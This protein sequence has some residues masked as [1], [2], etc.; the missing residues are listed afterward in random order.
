MSERWFIYV[1]EG[2]GG[3][4]RLQTG[5]EKGTWGAKSPGMFEGL[6]DGET[7]TFAQGVVAG[8]QPAPRGFPVKNLPRGQ[9]RLG[10]LVRARVRGHQY[11]GMSPIWPDSRDVLA[12]AIALMCV[13]CWLA[14]HNA[15]REPSSG[16][17]LRWRR[18]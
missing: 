5:L 15:G 6:D 14:S 7:V 1:P 11:L 9:P 8:V 4:E 13:R 3:A 10:R 16:P 2:G 17:P 12:A 18:W